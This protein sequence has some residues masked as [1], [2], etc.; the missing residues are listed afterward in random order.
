M[1]TILRLRRV[2]SQSLCY[3]TSLLNSRSRPFRSCPIMRQTL[4]NAPTKSSN[5][6]LYRCV[7]VKTMGRYK[8]HAINLQPFQT[9]PQLL[10]ICLRDKIMLL[11]LSK[12]FSPKFSMRS[13]YSKNNFLFCLQIFKSIS[14]V[15]LLLNTKIFFCSVKEVNSLFKSNFHNIWNQLLCNCWF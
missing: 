8:I 9:R 4:V 14:K 15:N 13:L 7:K 2:Q 6:S 10:I 12:W 11:K 5:C 3:L 1:L